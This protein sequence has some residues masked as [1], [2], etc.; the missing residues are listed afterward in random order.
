MTVDVVVDG[1]TRRPLE[2]L[3]ASAPEEERNEGRVYADPVTDEV[4]MTIGSNLVRIGDRLVLFDAGVGSRPTG[5]FTGGA[6]RSALLARGIAV[7][8]ITDVVFTHL[9]ADHIGWATQGGRAF[10][11][12]ATYHCDRRDWDHF[13][14]DQYDMPAW[15]AASTFPE[16]DAASIRLAPLADSMVFW[17]GDAQIIPGIRSIDAAGHTPGTD[18]FVLE[19][20]GKQAMLLGDIV[21]FIPE[22]LYS[23]RFPVHLDT[24]AALDSIAMVRSL[25][26]ESGMPFSA[27]H[28]TG[29]PWGRLTEQSGRY[30]WHL[31]ADA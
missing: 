23:W 24:D 25:L 7:G 5:N 15:E 16:S 19:S 17:E 9:H 6:L 3:Y 20:D 11:P 2:A 27:A 30:T 28:F 22:L 26:V 18:A 1:E 12:S 13:T 8:D 4:V 31:I 10:F 14:A 21:H 29:M